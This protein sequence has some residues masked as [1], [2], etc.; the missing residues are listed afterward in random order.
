MKLSRKKQPKIR[1]VELLSITEA[2]SVSLK[3]GIPVYL[4]HAG[5]EE[6]MR[7]DFIFNAGQATEIFPLVASAT[8]TMLLEGSVNYTANE[9]NSAFD[10]HGAFINPFCQKDSAG[11][12][13]FLL[14]KYLENII[15]LCSEIIFNPLFPEDELKNLQKKRLQMYLMN[16]E[17]VQVMA[18]D[19]FLESVFGSAHPYGRQAKPLDFENVTSNM[20]KTFHSR[21]YVASNMAIIISGNIH[22]KTVST[23]NHFFGNLNTPEINHIINEVRIKGHPDRKAFIEKKDAVQ[24]AIRIG[25]ATINKKHSDYNGL[26]IMD[27]ILGG[28]FGSRLMKNIREDK[29]YTY[30]ISSSVISLKK[31]GYKIIATE[32]GKKHTKKTLKEIYKEIRLLQTTFVENRELDVVKSYMAGEMVR[33]FDGPFAL[34]ES[35][36]AAWD[37]GLGNDYYYQLAEKIRTISP[38][39]I[40][41][42]ANTYYNIDDLFE[43]TAGSK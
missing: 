6:L 30:G 8:N 12:T 10:F 36:R 7:I 27:T 18:N 40:I 39:E 26:M 5:S 2:E 28:Y 17:K 1:P 33:M 42:L 20:L 32:V 16:R 9:I 3:N 22:L 15:E 4:I 29:G 41:S 11:V 23:L 34:A 38:D 13:V 19:K 43:I 35:F 14:N 21:Y 31:S 25:S 24:T 37:Y